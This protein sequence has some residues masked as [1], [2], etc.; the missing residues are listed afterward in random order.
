MKKNIALNTEDIE[1][2]STTLD[3]IKETLKTLQTTVDGLTTDMG[4]VDTDISAAIEKLRI[5]IMK[6]IE[7]YHHVRL[8][9]H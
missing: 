6:Y 7:Y 3:N 1:G 8:L 5:E 9:K 2:H 4:N